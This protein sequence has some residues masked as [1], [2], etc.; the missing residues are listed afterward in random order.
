M[1]EPGKRDWNSTADSWRKWHPFTER[2]VRPVTE[3][4]L[5]MAA[6]GSGQCILDLATGL[7]AAAFAAARRAGETGSVLAVDKAEKMLAN[8]RALLAEEGLANVAFATGDL[9]ALDIGETGFDAAICRWGLMFAADLDSTLSRIRG[10][11]SPGARFAAAVW[12]P[13]DRCPTPTLANRVLMEALGLPP[14]S[15]GKG[16][17][18]ALS[19]RAAL[20]NAFARAGFTSV[21][22][23][24]VDFT[25]DFRNADEYVTYRRERTSL[26]GKIAHLPES[27]R[28]RAWAAV[29]AEARK[30]ARPDRS[31][32]LVNE[33]LVVVGQNSVQQYF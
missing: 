7:G 6:I 4:M 18:F 14:V 23:Q 20:E 24:A 2:A 26:E 5:E 1:S 3:A 8:A 16:T 13:P 31:I 30:L 27:E 19:D 32:R 9:D 10:L 11:L 33:G 15:T 25:Y 12:G 21:D 29:A 22:S 28:E 17:P